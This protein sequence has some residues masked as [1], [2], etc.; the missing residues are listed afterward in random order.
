MMPYD[1]PC[2]EL[3]NQHC[4]VFYACKRS[5]F[6]LNCLNSRK[7][8][9]E[10]NNHLDKWLFLLKHLAELSDRPESTSRGKYIYDLLAAAELSTLSA[11]Q[12]SYQD[13]LK[14]YRD[15]NN[16]LDT[17]RRR[18]KEGEELRDRTG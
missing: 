11:E 5:L 17:S 18:L 12:N 10:L 8:I 15:M 1:R 2:R 6:I 9:D 16:I 4:E 3:K 7:N 14:Y 13:S